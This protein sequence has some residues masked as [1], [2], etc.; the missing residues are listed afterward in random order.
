VK[1]IDDTGIT[2][3][4]NI[5]NGDGAQ[6]APANDAFTVAE[7]AGF[8][9]NVRADNGSG[10][11]KPDL[12]ITE[13]N[14]QAAAVG[15]KILLPSG[16][17]LTLN[18]NGTF[19][20][21]TNGAFNALAGAASGAQ[22]LT[23]TDTFTYTVVGGATATVTIT[24][25]GVDGQGDVLVGSVLADNLF[26]GIG[27]DTV[28]GL[29]GNDVIDGGDGNDTLNGGAGD[30]IILGGAGIDRL[31]GGK[32]ADA[33]A[34][35][36]G[37]DTYVVDDAGDTVS[38]AAGAGTDTVES[39]IDYLLGA[40]I[41]NLVLTGVANTSGIGNGLNNTITG[42]AGAN[43]IS[44]GAGN[45]V[46]GGQGGDD[47][48]SGGAG[49]DTMNGG[50]G[51][52]I[53][54]GGDGGDK[55]YGEVGADTLIGGKDADYLDGGSG[56]DVI[57]SGGGNDTLLGGQGKDTMRGGAGSDVYSVD[58]LLD[59]VFELAG[60]GDDVVN[61]TV[62]FVLSGNVE[63]LN[64]TGTAAINGTG[65]AGYNRIYGNA[66]SNIIDGGA[67]ADQMTGGQGA[68]VYIVDDA[69]DQTIE[70]A[71]EGS[72]TVRASLSW[73]L[74]ANLES[75]VLTG[76]AANGT[77]NGE[78]NTLTGNESGNVLMGLDG[79][80][81]LIGNGGEDRLVGGAGSDNLGGGTGNDLIEGGAGNNVLTG[82]T[83]A[84]IFKFG[85]ESVRLSGS[86]A[87]ALQTDQV[88]DFSAAEGD[89]IDLS[90]IDADSTQ[91]GD[92]A[93]TFVSS[94][95][96]HAGEAMLVYD[97][98][99]NQTLVRLDIDGDGK[100]DYQLRLD[101]DATGAPVLTGASNPSDGGWLL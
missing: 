64:L 58:N 93:F 73:T 81:K 31:D 90:S 39:A 56:D 61:S 97:M 26:A 36:A 54:D 34:G 87:L 101:G 14:G 20:Y 74:G 30:D 43:V 89:H 76:V 82:G 22:N 38:E 77:G 52:D 80:D 48:L 79:N 85:V 10:A 25:N 63:V 2:D 51:N 21:L 8:V 96:F 41:E 45:D 19:Q 23:A 98:G 59:Q 32:G 78:A 65:D 9:G 57:N 40:N 60:E 86:S 18:A 1:T 94:F 6:K 11:D 100:A 27:S 16:A 44:A 92:Q 75:L 91:A 12:A 72:D 17:Y 62:S 70:L 46:V 67:G 68:D 83:G 13:V 99:A 33:M 49:V 7:N 24:V 69:G 47:T 66:A 15:V 35:G 28:N 95:G 88:T 53:L 29:T 50:T 3:P 5:P 55:L 4:Q 37:N 71:G 84:D 42:N